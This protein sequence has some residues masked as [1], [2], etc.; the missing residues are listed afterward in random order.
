VAEEVRRAVTEVL[1]LL[2][3]SRRRYTD[4]V[5]RSRRAEPLSIA[6][7]MQWSLLPPLTCATDH[8]SASGILEPAY[9]IGGDTFDSP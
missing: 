5:L 3:V 4:L 7:E 1:V 8:I 9:A 6:A 2:I